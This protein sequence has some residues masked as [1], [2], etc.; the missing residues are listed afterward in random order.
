MS[1][2][3]FSENALIFSSSRVHLKHLSKPYQRSIRVALYT[4]CFSLGHINKTK[5]CAGCWFRYLLFL[6]AMKLKKFSFNYNFYHVYPCY[7]KLYHKHLIYVKTFLLVCSVFII[8]NVHHVMNKY[9]F[10][11]CSGINQQHL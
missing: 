3:R 9:V 6:F 5:F 7:L 1:S 8:Q 10:T 11:E 4:A 2:S